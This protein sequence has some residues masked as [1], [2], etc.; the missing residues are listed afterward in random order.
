MF[1]VRKTIIWGSMLL[2]AG[3]AS[4]DSTDATI[5]G[6]KTARTEQAAYAFEAVEGNGG[7]FRV[8]KVE[9]VLEEKGTPGAI[10][11]IPN[12]VVF[13]VLQDADRQGHPSR[14]TGRGASKHSFSRLD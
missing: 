5:A 8:V 7:T 9:P 1:E 11:P 4:A 6:K 2:L 3:T 10:L 13:G 12:G 14:P